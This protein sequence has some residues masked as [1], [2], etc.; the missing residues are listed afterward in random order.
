M[1]TVIPAIDIIDGKCVR[2]VQGDYSRSKVYNDNP[3]DVAGYFRDC[4]VE[5]IHLVDLDG[6]KASRP[7][8]LR[9]LEDI[10]SK[11][12]LKVEFGGGVKN[13]GAVSSVF[14]A[15]ASRVIC[16]SV[17]CTEPE[18]FASWLEK[19]G[20]AKIVLGADVRDGLVAVNGW[21]EKSSVSAEELLARFLSSGLQ[22]TIVTDIS[23]DGMLSGPAVEMYR[24]LMSG[25]PEVRIIASG[26]VGSE[27]DLERLDEAGVP[28]VVV[29]KAI[30]E[31]RIDLAALCRR[32]AC[33]R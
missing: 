5:L 30:Y 29:G 1:I 28:A 31:G 12:S 6:A 11:T 9:V 19:Y 32:Q 3:V 25:F 4:G 18:L 26:G 17:A 10:V 23:K 24:S 27:A 22:T 2:L 13:S 15:G 14:D 16:G 21:E 8:N 33:A 20:G 7:V